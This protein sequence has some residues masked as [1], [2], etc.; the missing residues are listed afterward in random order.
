MVDLRKVMASSQ[1]GTALDSVA[2]LPVQGVFDASAAA[3][4]R[5]QACFAAWRVE[6]SPRYP[7][8]R[9]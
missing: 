5:K 2:I 9:G 7:L 6:I 3:A 8:Y 4:G 1:T